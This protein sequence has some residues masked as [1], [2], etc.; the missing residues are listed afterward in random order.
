MSKCQTFEDLQSYGAEKI[1]EK[2]HISR[3][4]VELLLTKSYG[5]IGRVQ[6]MGFMSILER[7]FGIDLSTVRAEYSEYWQEHGETLPPKESVILQPQSN[8]KQKWV[9]AGGVLIALLMGGGYLLQSF[10]SNEPRAE[11]MNLNSL[12]TVAAT[13]LSEE[14]VSLAEESNVSETASQTASVGE[15]NA[16]ALTIRPLYKV[17]VGM[18]DLGSGVK[19]QQITGDPIVVDT[20]KNWLIV[21]GH[22]RVE[23]DSSEGKQILKEK[24]TVRFV[25]EHG[26]LQQLSRA[27]FLERNGGKNW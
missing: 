7:E 5:E 6:F 21:L 23:I 20:T 12:S 19:T 18:I 8:T 2:T 3:D 16:T 4:K 14:N 27:E 15:T 26:K 1:H 11:V 24:E 17:W 13:T 10:L 22:G 25:S 9:L